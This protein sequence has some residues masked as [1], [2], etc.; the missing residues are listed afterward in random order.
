MVVGK[1]EEIYPPALKDYVKVCDGTYAGTEI[2][3]MESDLLI[4][5]DF[6]IAVPI[7]FVLLQFFAAFLEIDERAFNFCHYLLESCLLDMGSLKFSPVELAA[8]S[9]FLT[10]KLMRKVP[11]GAA[12]ERVTQMG[13]ARVKQIAKEVFLIMQRQ[14]GSELTAIKSKFSSPKYNEVSKFRIEKITSDKQRSDSG[15]NHLKC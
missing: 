9:L 13:H 15:K 8:G 5:L 4:A 12:E 11:W 3:A 2:I 10:L 6:D 7:T 1:F 14:E